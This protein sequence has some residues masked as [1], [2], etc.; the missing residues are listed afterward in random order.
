MKTFN[1]LLTWKCYSSSCITVTKNTFDGY[2]EANLLVK[3]KIDGDV[4]I[5]LF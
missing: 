4:Q 3:L 5:S 2:D 1:I